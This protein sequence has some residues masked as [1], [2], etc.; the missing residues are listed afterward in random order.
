MEAWCIYNFQE[1]DNTEGIESQHIWFNSFIK[2]ENKTLFYKAWYN[3]GIKN[4]E[5]ILN[6]NGSFLSYEQFVTKY[7]INTNF[8]TYHGIISAIPAKWKHILRLN[9]NEVDSSHENNA[10]VEK[11]MK[12]KK[13]CKESYRK[14]LCHFIDTK[15]R[16]MGISKWEI[17]LDC[18]IDN[19]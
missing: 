6:E 10:G 14:F 11:L 4:V 1:P 16:M 15:E 2:I 5:D 3:K 8:L 18:T 17:E 7:E 19:I 13:V 9:L 12:L